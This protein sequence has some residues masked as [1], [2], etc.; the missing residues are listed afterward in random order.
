MKSSAIVAVALCFLVVHASAG[1]LENR[2]TVSP[3]YIESGPENQAVVVGQT[4]NGVRLTCRVPPEGTSTVQ[5]LEFGTDP[6]GRLVSE[7]T[8][9]LPTHPNFIRY[10][11]DTDPPGS[12]RYDLIITDVTLADGTY[13]LCRDADSVPPAVTQRGA[14]LIV[15]ES[16]PNCTTTMSSS[17][18]LEGEYH[19]YECITYF[20]ATEGIELSVSWSGPE[21]YL[22]A[23][24]STSNSSW[25]GLSTTVQRGMDAQTYSAITNVSSKGLTKPDSAENI[26]TWNY[27]YR[28]PQLLVNWPPKNMY[29]TPDQTNYNVG[30]VITCFADA[31][32]Q[33]DIY[34]QNLNTSEVY[35]NPSFVTTAA[36]VGNTRW[37]CHAENFI[38]GIQY[39]NDYFTWITVNPVPTTQAPGP[40]TTTTT[41]PPEAYCSDLTGRW[42][43]D[44]PK[45]V[46]CLW[47]DLLTNGVLYGLFK[48]N[49]DTY[50]QDLYGRGQVN[51]FDQGGFATVAPGTLGVTSYAF[52]C[53]ACNG[54]EKMTVSSIMRSSSSA[55]ECGGVGV[56]N[57]VADYVFYRVPNAAP[58]N[59]SPPPP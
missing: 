36:M 21:P 53:K 17:V 41:P 20:Q 15:I 14:D 59:S 9:L 1:S 11:L 51:T 58:C 37:R 38:N 56:T 45:A 47:V 34:W 12:G 26:P 6:N 10:S 7:G 24:A 54:V 35:N 2:K 46:M 32:P 8:F 43:S 22:T 49:S 33:A 19:T 16:T 52:E 18:V 30:V 27:V 57:R 42:Q 23:S 39:Y 40:S 29:A 5:W 3:H 4:P 44:N 48:N 13:Y 55:S 31:F 50:Y 25:S 28:S